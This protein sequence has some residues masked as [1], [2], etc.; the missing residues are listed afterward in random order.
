MRFYVCHVRWE[1]IN[2]LLV[3]FAFASRIVHGAIIVNFD[4]DVKGS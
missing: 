3:A 2:Y 4:D 1:D